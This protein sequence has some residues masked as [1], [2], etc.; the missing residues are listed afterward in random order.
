M[1]G[2]RRASFRRPLATGDGNDQ[3]IPAGDIV[4]GYS[5]H[6]TNVRCLLSC[7]V[8]ASALGLFVLIKPQCVQTA[9][10]N[11]DVPKHQGGALS[12]YGVTTIDFTAPQNCEPA[13][14]GSFIA[15]GGDFSL[16][17]EP[18]DVGVM[19]VRVI[20]CA[21]ACDCVCD[22]MCVC[23]RLHVIVCAIACDCLC[24]CVCVCV[25][26]RAR[27]RLC[28]F[29][30]FWN[31]LRRWGETYWGLCVVAMGNLIGHTPSHPH[32]DHS[33][34]TVYDVGADHRLPF[35]WNRDRGPL[36]H[37]H[38]RWLGVRWDPDPPRPVLN[39]KVG[40]QYVCVW[41]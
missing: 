12:C 34:W 16:N 4:V 28:V 39:L 38:L 6:Q 31:L 2:V 21:I 24:V 22:C 23:V 14:D 11:D 9:P 8:C 18:V 15:P 3:D 26:A 30:C 37:G 36:E 10:P 40:T 7:R 35:L 25:C 27:V 19:Q 13:G 20:V 29:V 1:D 17:W 33:V 32:S 41:C 5:C